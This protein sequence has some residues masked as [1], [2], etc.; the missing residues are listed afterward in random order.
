MVTWLDDRHKQAV[1]S[2][3]ETHDFKALQID[4]AQSGEFYWKIKDR[5]NFKADVWYNRNRNDICFHLVGDLFKGKK[6]LSIGG[7]GWVEEEFLSKLGALE[8]VKTDIAGKEK[9]GVLEADAEALPFPP[10]S[11]DAVV[12]RDMIEHVLDAGKVFSEIRRVLV[13]HGFLLMTT[14]NAYHSPIDGII[15]RRAY[16]PETFLNEMKEQEFKVLKKA[17]NLPYILTALLGLT[18][19]GFDFVLDEFKRNA[20][21][22]TPEQ[23]YYLGT[24]LFV[25]A[26]RV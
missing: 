15:H 8:V 1:I 5:K 21:R 10:E 14:P 13:P 12:S 9:D 11:F 26:R 6:V 19:D 20:R 18:E 16:S 25:L 3:S 22:Y 24:Q 17:G 4:E 23:L 7:R 2:Y